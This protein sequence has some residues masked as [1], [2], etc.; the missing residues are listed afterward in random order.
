MEGWSNERM[1]ER[2]AGSGTMRPGASALDAKTVALVRAAAALA[3]G[4]ITE[5]EQRFRE[6]RAAGVPDLW[7]EE[8]LRSEEHTSELQSRSDLVCRLLLEKKKSNVL[9][10]API[11]H[12]DSVVES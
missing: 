3:E 4:R 7:V 8:L 6:A 10:A 12:V 1:G 9:S 5:L 2:G 11:I